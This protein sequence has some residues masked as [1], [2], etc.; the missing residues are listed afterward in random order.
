MGSGCEK[1]DERAFKRLGFELFSGRGCGAV[2]RKVAAKFQRWK[3]EIRSAFCE[4][5]KNSSTD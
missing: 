5:L 2:R 4:G 3:R 1:G